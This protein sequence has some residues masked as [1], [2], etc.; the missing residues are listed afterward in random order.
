[1]S[2]LHEVSVDGSVRE[3]SGNTQ[4]G[5]AE[6]ADGRRGCTAQPSADSPHPLPTAMWPEKLCCKH[7]RLTQIDF[8]SL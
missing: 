6:K 8:A 4:L 7:Q 3:D 1:M 5:S 2:L